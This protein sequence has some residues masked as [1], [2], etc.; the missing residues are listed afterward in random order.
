M[1][2][3]SRGAAYLEHLTSADRQLL[4]RASGVDAAELS[5]RPD[6]VEEALAAPGVFEAIFPPSLAG[7]EA[8]VGVSPFLLFA[9]AVHRSRAELAEMSYIQE[10]TGPRQRVPVFVTDQLRAFLE[11][12]CHRLFL[13]ELLASYTHVSSGAVNVRRHGVTYRQRFNELDLTSLAGWLDRADDDLRP[14]LL[15]RMGDLALFLTGVFPDHTAR[16]RFAPIDVHRL[17]SGLEAAGGARAGRLA[18][19]LEGR[20]AVGMLEELGR[21]WYRLAFE[22]TDVRT[23]GLATLESVSDRFVDARRVL[24]HLTDQHLFVFRAHWF[25]PPG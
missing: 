4:V 13:T 7:H 18:E 6:C 16:S 3:R 21:R 15:R 24:N 1:D 9:V 17:A 14:G 8:M 11:D 10:W 2:A 20:G 12:A 25:P 19:A 5:S 23:A 22:G